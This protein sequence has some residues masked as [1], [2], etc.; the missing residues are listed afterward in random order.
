[1]ARALLAAALFGRTLAQERQLT[2]Y[3]SIAGYV[4]ASDVVP[5]SKIDLD[6]EEIVDAVGLGTAAGIT[7]AIR[8]YTDGGG[9]LCLQTDVDAATAGTATTWC[10]DTTKALGN[11]Q[12]SSSVRTIKGFATS[13]QDKMTGWTTYP[14]YKAYYNDFNYADTFIT[15]AATHTNA[16]ADDQEFREQMIKKGAAYM[17]V[18]MY[19]LH[20]FE[21]AIKDCTTGDITANDDEVHAWDEGWAFYAGSLTGENHP[22][23]DKGQ[24]LYGLAQ[25]RAD[26]F[27]T[28]TNDV[29]NANTVALAAA[30]AGRDALQQAKCADVPAQLVILTQQMTVPLVQGTLKYAWE[31]DPAQTGSACA[32]QT[33]PFDAG[34]S[35][36]WAEGWTFASAILPQLDACDAAA[37]KTVKDALDGAAAAPMAGGLAAV[38]SAI[39]GCY[40]KMGITCDEVG[41]YQKSGVVFNGMCKCAGSVASKCPAESDAA[42][43]PALALGAAAAAAGALLL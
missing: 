3:A 16:N 19:V 1:M 14:V 18:W 15:A 11:S 43:A 33:A 8:I 20:E 23:A 39:E 24:L 32:G 37:A 7:E 6:M 22:A 26:N 40:T 36:A 34:C 13:G 12:K 42:A 28:T 35:K 4:P 21:D 27:G 25:S 30:N 17:A 5:H 29:A 9:G 2:T 38:K 10:T 31:A 41:E